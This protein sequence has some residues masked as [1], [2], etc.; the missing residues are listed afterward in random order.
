MVD[1]VIVVAT[2]LMSLLLAGM[3]ILRAQHRSSAGETAGWL[4]VSM[5]IPLAV[6]L[7]VN[8]LS[9][10]EWPFWALPLITISYCILELLLDGILKIDFR[11]NRLLGPYLAVYYLGQM[12]MI[13][14]A[15]LVSKP[16]GFI[17]LLTYFVN[18]GATAFSFARVGHGEG[19]NG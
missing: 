6:G 13:G 11:H 19:K 9:Q 2:N 5:A 8:I 15:F 3:F 18:L 17:T 1:L 4:A 10:R 12:A 16:F 14:Y 7:V